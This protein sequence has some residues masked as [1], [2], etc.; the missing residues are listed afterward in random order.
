MDTNESTTTI[1]PFGIDLASADSDADTHSDTSTTSNTSGTPIDP[2]C[3]LSITRNRTSSDRYMNPSMIMPPTGRLWRTPP[4]RIGTQ[5]ASI[6]TVAKKIIFRR[7]RWR[8][9]L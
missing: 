3:R 5:T 6:A 4:I 9:A 2:P 7:L 1:T 8:A